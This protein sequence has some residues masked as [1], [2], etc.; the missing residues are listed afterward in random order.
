MC[1]GGMNC[2]Q[3][4]TQ[5]FWMHIDLVDRSKQQQHLTVQ[6]DNEHEIDPVSAELKAC[7]GA[8]KAIVPFWNK[9]S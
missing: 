3:T 6:R 5:T 4:I 8:R 9:V 2:L 1:V 7:H